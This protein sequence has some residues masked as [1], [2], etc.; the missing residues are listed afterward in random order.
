MTRRGVLF[1]AINLCIRVSDFDLSR[2]AHKWSLPITI[3]K[4]VDKIFII[5]KS[6]YIHW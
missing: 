4:S 3:S 2:F 6:G 5:G 1:T